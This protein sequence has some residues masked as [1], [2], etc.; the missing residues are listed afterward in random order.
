M[1]AANVS[2]RAP[3]S[4]DIARGSKRRALA[5]LT[6]M[7]FAPPTLILMQ[8]TVGGLLSKL[9]AT[10]LPLFKHFDESDTHF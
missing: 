5:R 4:S 8:T 3:P 7:F 2:N 1:R 6:R 9:A 10:F